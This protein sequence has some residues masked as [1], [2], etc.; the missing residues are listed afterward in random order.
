MKEN[1]LTY[2]FNKI[3]LRI[4]FLKNIKNIKMI[5]YFEITRSVMIK[6]FHSKKIISQNTNYLHTA[7]FFS[8]S[9]NKNVVPKARQKDEN[10]NTNIRSAKRLL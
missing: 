2:I 6:M 5:N 7:K 10:E 9:T 3:Y 1:F 4:N 8:S